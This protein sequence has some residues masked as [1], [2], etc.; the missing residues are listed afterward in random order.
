MTTKLIKLI[1]NELIKIFKRKSIYILFFISIITI[2][3]YN[4]INPD[5][6]SKTRGNEIHDKNIK[7]L[8]SN[9][10]KIK[11]EMEQDTNHNSDTLQENNINDSDMKELEDFIDNLEKENT[12]IKEYV[13]IKTDIDIAYLYN[14]YSQ[15]SWQRYALN[16]ENMTYHVGETD[17]NYSHD[18][19][20]C[21]KTIND[22]ELNN[23]S[24]VTQ[25]SYNKVKEKYN[26]Y[27]QALD[28]NNWKEFIEIKI[29]SLEEM[30]NGEDIA[31]KDK[32]Y[33]NADIETYKLQI[34]NNIEYNDNIL[35]QYLQEYRSNQYLLVNNYS[36][37][38]N[39]NALLNQ[40]ENNC[41]AKVQ[42]CKY[43]IENKINQDAFNLL[44][45]NKID[46]RNSF[47]KTFEHFNLI[48]AI[49]AIYI[50]CIIVT[51]EINKKTIKNVLT[52]PHKRSTILISKIMA[53]IITVIIAMIFIAIVQYI[54]GGIVFG[55]DSYDLEY[56]GYDY[57]NEQVFTMNL[58]EYLMLVG[59]TK[60]P[61]YIMIIVFCILMGVLNNNTAM[62][63]IL[64]L[65]IFLLANSIISE[66]SKVEEFSTI[67]RYF[68]TNNWDFSTFLFGRTSSVNGITPL[69]SVGIYSIYLISGLA[70]AI[71]K[72]NKKEINNV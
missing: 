18:I 51:E 15:S 50:S 43:A 37:I 27:V 46:A 32:K 31:D 19:T 49:I 53:C 56:I 62:T 4:Y 60:M 67:A 52:K 69:F 3:L 16:E 48:M 36:Q 13:N 2:I 58:F 45:E 34:N 72:F 1:R 68:I 55:F 59:L 65:I 26:K 8:E 5:Q 22:Y 41:K 20:N 21:L 47:I 6:N 12:L 30:K 61:M 10:E 29:A 17:I 54:V 63:I 42:L 24:N 14:K 44:P 40:E 11:K 23:N 7:Q 39:E 38:E 57:K 35:N 66:W 64:T 9:L 28:S 70:I 25:E 33:I 71:Y